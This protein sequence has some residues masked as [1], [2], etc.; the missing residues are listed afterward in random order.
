MMKA[1]PRVLRD[2]LQD[3][4]RAADRGVV[5][6]LQPQLQAGDIAA[7]ER[8]FELLRELVGVERGRRDQVEP[9]RRPRFDAR[10]IS[11]SR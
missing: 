9:G 5:D 10:M 1:T 6:L 4:G 11:P 8:L 2:R 7:G 3:R